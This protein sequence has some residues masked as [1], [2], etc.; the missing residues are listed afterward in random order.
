[1]NKLIAISILSL[2]ST[3]AFAQNRDETSLNYNNV[4]VG[5]V[6]QTITSSDDS[7]VNY[8]FTGY[9][10]DGSYL[11][12]DHIFAIG[13]YASSSN[14]TD[15][16]QSVTFTSTQLGLGYRYPLSKETDLNGTVTYL[17]NTFTSDSTGTGYVATVGISSVALSPDLETSIRY[18]SMSIT[19]DGVKETSTGYGLG[20]K[21]SFTKNVYA[22]LSYLTVTNASRYILS[23]GYKF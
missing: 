16:D 8:T 22:G 18:N 9:G 23:I 3:G 17:S 20:A 12:T 19:Q 14:S 1:M 10:F 15:F 11:L 2:L 13:S 7:S 6:S 21:Y 4:S 5:Y